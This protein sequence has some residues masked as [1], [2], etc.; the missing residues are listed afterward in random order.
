MKK[1]CALA[2][3]AGA[4]GSRIAIAAPRWTFFP[5]LPKPDL[6]TMTAYRQIG[7]IFQLSIHKQITG[8]FA[9][10]RGMVSN[11]SLFYLLLKVLYAGG[12]NDF[13]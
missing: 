4:S 10:D 3:F 6:S 11:A 5:A 8:K 12:P 2:S 9:F 13:G 7:Q 1:P